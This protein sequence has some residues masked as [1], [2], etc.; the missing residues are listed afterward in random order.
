MKGRVADRIGQSLMHFGP[1]FS[2]GLGHCTEQRCI[3]PLCSLFHCALVSKADTP[4][5]LGTVWRIEPFTVRRE[6]QVEEVLLDF[7]N[8]SHSLQFSFKDLKWGIRVTDPSSFWK[9]LSHVV[10]CLV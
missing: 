1:C 4:I 9:D 2:T 5:S 10:S 3:L 7:P 8:L 6:K